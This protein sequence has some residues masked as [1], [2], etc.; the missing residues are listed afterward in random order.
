MCPCSEKKRP[1]YVTDGEQ[2]QLSIIF[3]AHQDEP[4]RVT[5]SIMLG[6][7]TSNHIS[8]ERRQPFIL[9]PPGL[10]AYQTRVTINISAATPKEFNSLTASILLEK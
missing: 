8:H 3:C 7:R 9:F 2:R 10:C 4:R 1:T 5:N 6:I